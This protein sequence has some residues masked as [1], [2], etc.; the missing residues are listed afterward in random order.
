[1]LS[2]PGTKGESVTGVSLG[3]CAQFYYFTR[4]KQGQRQAGHLLAATGL[5]QT[6]SIKR[7]LSRSRAELK[8]AVVTWTLCE[9]L[10]IITRAGKAGLLSRSGWLGGQ[11]HSQLHSKFCRLRVCIPERPEKRVSAQ[12]WTNRSL[13]C[14][15][16]INHKADLQTFRN[17]K[18]GIPS[19]CC[20]PVVNKSD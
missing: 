14:F 5:R 15:Q 12:K 9:L 16:K 8:R 3:N 7:H 17:L 18:T 6:I 2:E 4:T 19:S 10:Y 20:S 1:M 13:A 11:W